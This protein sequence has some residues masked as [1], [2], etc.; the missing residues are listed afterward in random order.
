MIVVGFKDAFAVATGPSGS[1]DRPPKIDGPPYHPVTLVT[2]TGIPASWPVPTHRRCERVYTYTSETAKPAPTS[3]ILNTLR[4]SYPRQAHTVFPTR[5]T[6]CC[7]SCWLS[8]NPLRAHSHHWYWDERCDK[9]HA[10]YSRTSGCSQLFRVM[11]E[12][13]ADSL[14][15]AV[16]QNL[17]RLMWRSHSTGE[18]R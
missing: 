14:Y 8:K 18:W 9:L 4:V 1:R 3:A 5:R 7:G 6:V 11:V 16:L 13:R 15:R 10:G 2:V 12:K 17:A